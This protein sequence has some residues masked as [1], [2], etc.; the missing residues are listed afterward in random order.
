MIRSP[1]GS[2]RTRPVLG[3]VPAGYV[4]TS[5]RSFHT[6]PTGSNQ[7]QDRLYI[8]FGST[9]REDETLSGGILGIHGGIVWVVYL[10]PCIVLLDLLQVDLSLGVL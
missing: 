5:R 8:S 9:H 2:G 3:V 10:F 1:A 6:P 4:R 7:G